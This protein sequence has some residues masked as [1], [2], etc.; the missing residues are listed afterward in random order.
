VKLTWAKSQ[1]DNPLINNKTLIAVRLK[2]KKARI[3]GQV[4][5]LDTIEGLLEI[6]DILE[7]G[8]VYF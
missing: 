1:A 4:E 3:L 2:N 8:Q 7:R 6:G 5:R